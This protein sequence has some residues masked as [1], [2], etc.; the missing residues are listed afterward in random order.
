[1]HP[2][3]IRAREFDPLR[4]AVQVQQKLLRLALAAR[5][6]AVTVLRPVA[7]ALVGA[8]GIGDHL[9]Q[10]GR[11]E[12]EVG[13]EG[14]LPGVTGVLPRCVLRGTVVV[15]HHA[16][17]V[18]LTLHLTCPMRRGR[19]LRRWGGVC[20]SSTTKSVYRGTVSVIKAR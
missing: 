19:F 11:D 1:L 15:C 18:L 7:G 9:P 14:A 2:F 5:R 10:E 3:H 20:P 13:V 17:L 12:T 16:F 8:P 6:P 4:Q